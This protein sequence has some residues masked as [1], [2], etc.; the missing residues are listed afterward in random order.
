MRPVA[1]SHQSYAARFEKVLAHIDAHLDDEL[2][3]DGLSAIACFSRYHFHRQFSAYLGIGAFQYVRLMRLRR[4]ARRLAG[5]PSERVIDVAVEA[6]F[7]GPEA[8][9][10]AFKRA[11]GQ[12]PSAFRRQPNWETVCAGFA[13]PHF[14]RSFAMQVRIVDF[15]ET[16][17][18]ALEHRGAPEDLRT[19][20]ERFIAWRRKT[21]LSP[22]Q[23]SRTFGIPYGNPDTV[24]AQ[25]FRFDVCGEVTAPVPPN[26]DGVRMLRIP[27]GRCAVVQHQG[28]TD[29]IGETIYPLYRDWLPDS[30]EEARDFPL[31]FQY[32]SVYPETATEDWRTDIYLPLK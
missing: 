9:A 8:F 10:R 29:R 5:N 30:G 25:D 12:T 13:F 31:F 20:V 22:V 24:R 21:G 17:V 1:S 26:E 15:S 18:A 6:G 14:T 19:T 4:A 32:L 11:F 23:T 7:E 3:V 27:P 2:S 16:R 28:S